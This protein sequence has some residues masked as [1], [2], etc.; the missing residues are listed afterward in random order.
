MTGSECPKC[1]QGF[2]GTP[3]FQPATEEHSE[4]LRYACQT[5]GYE[6][7]TPTADQKAMRLRQVQ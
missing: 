2:F 7:Y 3:R 6:V 4:S 1:Q 5:C